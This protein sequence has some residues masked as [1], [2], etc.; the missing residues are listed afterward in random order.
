MIIVPTVIML[1]VTYTSLSLSIIKKI[2]LLLD[3]TFNAAVDGVQMCIAIL[4]LVLG[5]LVA[6]SCAYKLLGKNE[7]KEPSHERL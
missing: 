1:A 5:I 4:L 6:A 7:D 2:T 3:G